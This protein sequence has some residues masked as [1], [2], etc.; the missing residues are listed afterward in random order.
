MDPLSTLNPPPEASG[1]SPL[2]LID[3]KSAASFFQPVVSIKKMGVVGLEALGRGIDTENQNKLIE[4]QDIYKQ[5]EEKKPRLALAA[6]SA[7]RGWKD[8]PKSTRK[9]Q[10]CFFS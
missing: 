9:S 10:V 7:R 6:F 5:L 3:Q 8:S 1:L 2:D 4:P